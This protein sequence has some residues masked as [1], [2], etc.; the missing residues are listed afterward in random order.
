MA[1]SLSSDGKMWALCRYCRIAI[2]RYPN[3]KMWRDVLYD[4]NCCDSPS[5]WHLPEY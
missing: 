3:G 4:S 2:F 5:S 1:A